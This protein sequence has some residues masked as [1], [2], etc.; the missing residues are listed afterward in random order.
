MCSSDL[1]DV[2][3]TEIYTACSFQDLTGQRTR[4]VV[5]VLRYL[6][7]RINAMISIWGLEDEDANADETGTA[8]GAAAPANGPFDPHDTR[9]DAHLLNGP[10]LHG[11]GVDQNAVDDLMWDEDTAAE[12]GDLEIAPEGE[13]PVLAE[14]DDEAARAER[15]AR[16]SV[17]DPAPDV[18][19]RA[20][21]FAEAD[22]F[23]APEPEA[24]VFAAPD[25]PQ[26]ATAMAEIG[27][28]HV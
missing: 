14:D 13:P 15:H 23:A 24:D 1:L 17:S 22:V 28:A 16:G 19:D 9:P 2:Q 21:V 3:A 4:K 8:A 27:R 12:T 6:E 7:S 20:D 10:Q 18:F 5:T 11:R 26:G 25:A